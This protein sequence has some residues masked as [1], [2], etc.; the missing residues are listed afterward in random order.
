[1]K[2][3]QDRQ[4]PSRAT[5][6][7]AA[8]V[9]CFCLPLV[10]C[11]TKKSWLRR[12]ALAL[13]ILCFA[14]TAPLQAQEFR[15]AWADVFHVGMGS[16]T[17]VNNMVS[18]LATGHYNAVVVQVVGY[19]DSG[20]ASHGAHW[21]SNILPWST[22]VTSSFDPLAY[23]C[24]QAHAKGIEV[25]A[26][27]GGSA[28]AMY[29]VSTSWPPAGN[30]TLSNHPE[31][32][33]APLANSEG[34]SPVLVDGN[35][36]L[37]MGSP[38]AQEY[39]VSIV[40]ELI[41]NYPIDGIN[42][43]DELNG[44]GYTAGFGYPAWSQADY[45]RSGLARYRINTG[46][47]GTPS[48]T[49]TAWADYR[50]RYK[51][52]LMARV[53]AEMQSIKTNPRQPLRHTSAA[54]AYSPVPTSCNFTGSV[55]YT[56]FCDWA[57]MLQHGWVDAVIP[58]TYSSST[59]NTWAD[60]SS[61]CWQYSRQIFLGMGGYLTTDATIAGYINYTRSK[62]L[63][64][65]AIYSY[66]VPNSAGNSDWWAYAAANVY[67]NVVSTPP[68]P[69]RNPATATEGIM[70]GRVQDANTGLYVDDA[71]VTVTGGPTVQ[72]DGNGY[73]V[74]TLIPATAGGTV[75]STTASKTGMPSQTIDTATVLAGDIVRYDF[76]LGAN[77]P[78]TIT[79]QP[80]NV[81]VLPGQPAAF[82][83][84]AS[85]TF[86]LSYQWRLNG[87]A[88]PGATNST[89]A[90]PSVRAANVGA[91]SVLVT[92]VFGQA[93]S[94]DALLV[95]MPVTQWGDNSFG[96]G[97]A[98]DLI[99]NAIA[100]AAGA[101]HMLALRAD[102]G[103]AAWGD[104]SSGQS[105]VPPAL[106]DAVAIAAG[107]YHNLAIRANG[108]VAAWGADD[109]GQTDV[110]AKLGNVI[111]IAAGTWHSVALRADGTVIAWGDNSFGQTNQPAGLTGVT[112]VAAGGNH[113]LAL[114]AD[115]TVVA[116]GENT[117]AEGY[118]VRQSI[119]P[120]GLTSVVAIGA[121]QY[122]SLAV[123]SNGTVVAWGDN[124][125]DQCNV[126]P[127]LANVV[128]VAGGG[129][130]SLALGADGSLTAWGADWNNQC[131]I[132]AGLFPA[133]GIAAGSAHTAVLLESIVPV[134]RLMNPAR[135]GSQFST[136]VQTLNRKCYALEWNS[137]LAS[138]NWT[139]LGTNTGN[140]ALRILADPSATGPR[141]FYRMRQW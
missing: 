119:V 95:L 118:A 72:T 44:A 96:Q 25:H 5:P 123:K 28:G 41:T 98:P 57:G 24:T 31:W 45:A 112:A 82:S 108:S 9:G 34:G 141:R 62:G 21:K 117:D 7:A 97:N 70:W 3:L 20:P 40:K 134:P 85:G 124:S 133:V 61:A 127:G 111:G 69:W 19:M 101:W 126:P 102:G 67:T 81:T 38:E 58:Q 120:W 30:S 64:G 87:V 16:Q 18:A 55:P 4:Q 73:Y 99:T 84:I 113:T 65:N 54:L 137:S 8:G 68:M 107:G 79:S 13:V 23:L 33:I 11:E 115:A 80:Q 138:T 140:G 71:T 132:P 51:N 94:T 130:H 32:F 105:E 1:M 93:L 121:G 17:E 110:P 125:Q 114:K 89:L 116:W 49:D 136:L 35:Y 66:A 14:S 60:R 15:A 75:H 56:Y 63:K 77:T 10:R 103:V 83:V 47:V 43:D 76:S 42:W 2:N 36:D 90:I 104:D 86:P 109:Y 26:W 37:D 88:L 52:E 135:K 128:A 139:S 6:R 74:A 50:R 53:Q 39:I 78:P 106:Q 91:Y 59:F 131:D 100:I 29:R 92:N 22:R 122:H 48:N 129:A 12:G 46:Y 27:L